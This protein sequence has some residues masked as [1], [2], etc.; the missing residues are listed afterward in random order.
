MRERHRLPPPPPGDAEAAR[1]AVR[2]AL[3]E[4]QYTTAW[5]AGHGAPLGL[6]IDQALDLVPTAA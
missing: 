3:G 6:I 2:V 5:T 4:R 1:D